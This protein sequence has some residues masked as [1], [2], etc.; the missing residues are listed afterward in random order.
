MKQHP[1]TAAA[2][3]GAVLLGAGAAAYLATRH[4]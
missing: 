2:V 1:K 4:K 3:G